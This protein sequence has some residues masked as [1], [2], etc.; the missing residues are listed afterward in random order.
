MISK[1]RQIGLFLFTGIV[2]A[3]AA[4]YTFP[5][6][7]VQACGKS[8]D[9]G[10]NGGSCCG[11]SLVSVDGN[12]IGNVKTGD[13]KVANV[14]TGDLLSGNKVKVLNNNNIANN[15]NIGNI[16]DVNVLSKNYLKDV[17]VLSKN[18]NKL[19]VGNVLS[20][21]VKDITIKSNDVFE[22]GSYVPI[23]NDNVQDAFKI[24]LRGHGCGC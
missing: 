4:I 9:G 19:K 13:V 11:S 12:N 5:M 3:V 14:K 7:Q 17:N 20:E 6:Q 21:N 1:A 16:N 10:S 8:C 15:N 24:L 2:L 18:Y 22:E 23:L